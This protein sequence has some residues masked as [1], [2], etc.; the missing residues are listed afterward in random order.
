M[1]TYFDNFYVNKQTTNYCILEER[2]LHAMSLSCQRNICMPLHAA[3]M[4]SHR[5]LPL[6]CRDVDVLCCHL[7][8]RETSRKCLRG[9]QE[10]T[11]LGGDHVKAMLL[12]L[13]V[14]VVC[15]P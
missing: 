10:L 7:L 3:F 2:C 15:H 6:V 4:I 5:V 11:C 13:S 14:T 1:I 8:G 12:V 9:I